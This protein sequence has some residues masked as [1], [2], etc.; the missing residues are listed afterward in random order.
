[1][2]LITRKMLASSLTLAMVVPLA[3]ACTKSENTDDK[4]ERVLKIATTMG[5]GD[6]EYFRQQFTEIFEFANPNVKIEVIPTMDDKYR[7]GAMKAG[8][9]MPDPMEKLKEVMQGDNPPDVVM[10]GF[11]QLPDII[12]SNM[13][14][15]LDPMITKD[16]FDTTGI[17]PA[18]IDGLKN[19]GG[20]KLYALAPTFSSS[21][22]IYNKKLFMDAGVDF[23][24]DGM[25][26]DEVFDL[27]KR[28]TKGEGDSRIN[29]FSFSTQAQGDLFYGMQMYTA[30][31]QLKMYDDAGEKMTVDTDQWEKVWTRMAQLQKDNVFPELIDPQK[32]M[33]RKFDQEN[34]FAYDD[35]M[36]S[37]LAMGIINY[38]QIQQITSANKNAASYKGYT[39]IDW[40]VVTIPSH[41][42][43]KG[44][45]GSIYMNGIMGINA[46]AQ[47]PEDAWKFIKFINGDDWAK[48]K[49][50]SSYNLVARSKYLKPKDGAEFHME[51]FYN[52][53][54][55]P[56]EN[57]FKLY[58]DMPNIYQVQE[59]GRQQ[60]NNVLQGKTTAREAL[61][62]WQTQGDAML[63]QMKE[64]PGEP[65]KPM[66]EAVPAG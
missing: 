43:A 4:Q 21:A 53:T 38:G 66:M 36:S 57:N 28:I 2:K 26:W 12:E 60:F 45:G 11:E 50:H 6:D 8:E 15:Q 34:P 35:F 33:N 44:V 29:G 19:A 1:M 52:V 56:P 18:V 39:P 22:L 5:F 16:K 24:K 49:S 17:V 7:Y 62:Q 48:L 40:D 14:T 41:P 64:N 63:K 59:I 55:V 3:V 30:P 42:E 25:T 61:K 37:R 65:P 47:N 10:V 9:K 32:G 20:G 58:R 13:L 54:P 23:P 31:L 46:K 27:S 51:A